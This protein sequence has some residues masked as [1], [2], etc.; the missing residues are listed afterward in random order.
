MNLREL[1]NDPAAFRAALLID[2]DNGPCKLADCLDPWQRDDF[3]A[4]DPTWRRVA[5]QDV[6]PRFMRAWLERGRGHS[7]TGDASVMATWVLFASRRK[8]SGVV[9]ACD[10]DQAGLVR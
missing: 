3:Q 8:L 7:K 5:G 6:E 4:L 2:G 9:A 10:R 1:Q